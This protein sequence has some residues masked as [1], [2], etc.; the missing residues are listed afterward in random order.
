MA[1]VQTKVTGKFI[2]GAKN[3]EEWPVNKTVHYNVWANFGKND[4][5]PV[6][7]AF[8]RFEPL[9]DYRRLFTSF[10]ATISKSAFCA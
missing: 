5:L 9:R 3:V 4:F 6:V 8:K 7:E 1:K 10:H 2:T